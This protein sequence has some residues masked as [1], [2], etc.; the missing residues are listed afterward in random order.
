ML[1]FDPKSH[2]GNMSYFSRTLKYSMLVN[3][4][5]IEIP[6]AKP[7]VKTFIFKLKCECM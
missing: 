3:K 6:H 4:E 5:I 2:P 1:T 7:L